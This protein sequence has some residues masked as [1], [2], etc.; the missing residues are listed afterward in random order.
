M[1]Q[2][3]SRPLYS[4]RPFIQAYMLAYL[5]STVPSLISLSIVVLRRRSSAAAALTRLRQILSAATGLHRFPAFCAALIGGSTLLQ[6]PFRII[7]GYLTKRGPATG[8]PSLLIQRL[9]R[10]LAALLSSYVSFIF[11]NSTPVQ[12]SH[13]GHDVQEYHGAAVQPLD[14]GEASLNE[15]RKVTSRELPSDIA[16][17]PA[18]AMTVDILSR[19]PG[20][21]AGKS[22]DLTLLAFTRAADIVITSIWSASGP[23]STRTNRIAS[24]STPTLFSLSAATIMHAWF[25]APHALPRTYVKWISAAAELDPRLL[26]ALRQA[27]YGNFVYGKETGIGSLLGSMAVDHGLPFEKG[28]PAKTIPV[29][30][31]IVHSGAGPSCEVHGLVRFAQGW[32]FAAKMYAPLQLL[33]LLRKLQSGRLGSSA[34]KKSA[35]IRAIAGTARSS[36]F[37]GAFISLF[38][39]GVCLGR[40][41]LGP[42]IFSRKT[43]TPQMWDGGLCVLSGCM[44]CGWS[45]LVERSNRREELLFFVLPRALS[46]WFPR[47]YLRENQ[48]K[49]H[50]TFSFSAALVLAAVQE[51]SEKV[52]GLLGSVLSQLLR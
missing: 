15:L 20:S 24:F 27:R 12:S 18:Q 44:A 47:R 21:L 3:I 34:A 33:I 30:C 32:M 13:P 23:H 26:L 51:R 31:E 1:T 8:K 52:R 35:F 16:A 4:L 5:S 22:M 19:P 49:E 6:T 10:F 40:T 25:Y 36:A 2:S 46:A 28:D 42:R 14:N 17:V 7:L 39:Y 9:A 29:A 38:Y 45:I 37:L 50:L 43:V 48:W 41:R 11:L